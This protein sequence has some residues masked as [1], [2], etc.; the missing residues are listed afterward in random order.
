MVVSTIADFLFGKNFNLRAWIT[1]HHE[2]LPFPTS[3]FAVKTRNH[4]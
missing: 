4:P 2:H 3:P 1:K